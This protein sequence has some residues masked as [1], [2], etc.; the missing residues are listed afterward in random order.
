MTHTPRRAEAAPVG[1]EGCSGASTP[2]KTAWQRHR[3]ET[4]KAT[5]TEVENKQRQAAL[6]EQR[7]AAVDRKHSD[8]ATGA[9]A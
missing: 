2:R 6:V 4:R 3:A 5:T 7:R 8:L 9:G 1:S